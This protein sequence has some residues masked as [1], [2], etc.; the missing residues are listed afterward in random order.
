[1]VVV[2]VPVVPTIRMCRFPPCIKDSS[3]HPLP[4]CFCS[5]P[6]H[7]IRSFALLSPTGDDPHPVGVPGGVLG[8]PARFPCLPP[9]PQDARTPLPQPPSLNS[10]PRHTPLTSTVH[11]RHRG[12]RLELKPLFRGICRRTAVA[13]TF[14]AYGSTQASIPFIEY[15]GIRSG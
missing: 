8:R 1:M 15:H 4:G 13:V 12:S 2:I 9:H 11:H 3:C 10:P 7:D 14:I 5:I 6:R